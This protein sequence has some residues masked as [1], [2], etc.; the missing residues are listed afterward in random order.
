M[1]AHVKAP[2]VLRAREHG[3]KDGG[4]QSENQLVELVEGIKSQI[5]ENNQKAAENGDKLI[6]EMKKLGDAQTETKGKVDEVLTKSA[7]LDGRLKEVEQKLAARRGG[8]DEAADRKSWGQ[9]FVENE[10]VKALMAEGKGR[11]KLD[12][13]AITSATGSGGDLIVPQRQPGIIS[14]P[15]RT[16]TIRDL[17]MPGTTTTNA[18]EYVKETGFTNNARPVTESQ[19][20][21]ESELTFEA[22]TVNVRTIAH[23]IQASRQ[24]LADAAQLQSHIDG[25]MVY[26]LKYKEELQLLGGD[27]LGQNLSGVKTEATAF[28]APILITGATKID[29]IRLAFLQ[30]IL[31][32]YPANGVIL[33]PIDWADIELTKDDN[34]RYIFAN[35]QGIAGPV[36]WGRPVV[37]TMAQTEGDFTA[38]AFNM[39]AQIF[40]RETVSVEVSTEDRDN[41]VKN[42][43]TILAEE[44]LALAV[45]R[46]EAIV[47]GAFDDVL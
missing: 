9:M 29:T 11:V 13:K 35:P 38:G 19:Q 26:G 36:L 8:G 1:N 47:D 43:V 23:W 2:A 37:E 40:D 20:K 6:T 18:V 24:V 22:A 25:R 41:F 3:R 44:R 28:S 32:E 10:K 31:A 39:A 4:G 33:H 46:P 5:K 12:V 14:A 7:D 16:M 30:V 17:L 21:P 27:G 34:G 15:Q 45:Y 42:M